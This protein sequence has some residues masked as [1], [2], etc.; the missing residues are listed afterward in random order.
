[1]IPG[2]NSLKTILITLEVIKQQKQLDVSIVHSILCLHPI[3]LH[4]TFS[5]SPTSPALPAQ[6]NKDSAASKRH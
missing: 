2:N 4:Q 5:T 6:R 1:M 3:L